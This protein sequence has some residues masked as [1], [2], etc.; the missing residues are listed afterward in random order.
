[1]RFDLTRVVL[2]F[3]WRRSCRSHHQG[4]VNL[5]WLRAFDA[6]IDWS[7][8]IREGLT[9]RPSVGFYKLFNF[10]NFDLPL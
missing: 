5:F 8:R 2:A 7:H 6:K 9:I 3:D 10:A 4:K 1:M